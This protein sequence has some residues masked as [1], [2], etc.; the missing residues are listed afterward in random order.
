MS[1]PRATSRTSAAYLSSAMSPEHS[2]RQI[3]SHAHHC[4]PAP[5]ARA[6]PD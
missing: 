3:T 2:D 1:T 5:D 4:P 6:R